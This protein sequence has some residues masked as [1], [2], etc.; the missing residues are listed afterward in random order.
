MSTSST[1]TLLSLQIL[2]EP[3]IFGM[4]EGQSKKEF[5][6]AKCH[7]L[8]FGWECC[9]CWYRFARV[10]ELFIMD[11]F[12]DLFITLCIVINTLFMAMDHDKMSTQ[13][14]ST[15][16]YGNYVRVVLFCASRFGGI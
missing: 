12:V 16:K 10:I 14:E 1:S 6:K 3:D 8:L 2:L 5:F 7:Q 15:L 13:L 4:E 9:P 11:A